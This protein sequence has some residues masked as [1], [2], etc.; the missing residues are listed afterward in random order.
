MQRD[1][2][3]LSTLQIYTVNKDLCINSFMHIIHKCTEFTSTKGGKW[4]NE[5]LKY[6]IRVV[7]VGPPFS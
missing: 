7:K 6:E 5:H 3:K 1:R 4:F 2:T